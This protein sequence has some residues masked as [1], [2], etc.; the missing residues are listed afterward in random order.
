VRGVV[1]GDQIL[2]ESSAWLRDQEVEPRVP[3]LNPTR[4]FRHRLGWGT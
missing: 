4:I 3:A 1:D 2:V